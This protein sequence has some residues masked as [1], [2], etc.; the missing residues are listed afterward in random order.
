MIQIKNV[1]KEFQSKT[2][3]VKALT[4]ISLNIKKGEIFG[5]IGTSGAGKSTL[6][7]CINLLEKPTSGDVIVDN[8]NITNLSKK[9]LREHRS[10]IGMIFQH[11]NLFEQRD[12]VSNVSFALEINGVARK[13]AVEKAVETLEL[14]GLKHKLNSYPSQLSGGQKQRV[15][16]ARALVNK[17]QVLLCDEATSALDS[18]TKHSI[19]KQLAEINKKFNITIVVV[20]HDISIAKN[21]CNTVAVLNNGRIE[22][23][24]K[25]EII[26]AS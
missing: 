8:I 24:G 12:V 11:F 25:P 9:Q 26:L 4:D 1:N 17:P 13:T 14:V 5:I 10:K 18:E 7:R 22:K 16:I 3:S 20:T 23:L 21:F 6:V 19:L 15:A 2:S